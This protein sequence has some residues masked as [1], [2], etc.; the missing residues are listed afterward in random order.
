MT[1]GFGVK[2]LCRVARS[3]H[4]RSLLGNEICSGATPPHPVAGGS[5]TQSPQPKEVFV[6]ME[7][8]ASEIEVYIPKSIRRREQMR[9]EEKCRRTAEAAIE[10]RTACRC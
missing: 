3:S 5:L 4:S 10:I 2:G 7:T 8:C 9:R 6:A 1:A